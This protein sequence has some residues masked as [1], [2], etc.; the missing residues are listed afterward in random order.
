[1]TYQIGQTVPFDYTRTITG[2]HLSQRVWHAVITPPHKEQATVEMFKARGFH[3]FYP[4]RRVRRFINGKKHTRELP[5][6]TRIV[7][8]RF[9]RVPHWDVM[10]ERGIIVGVFSVFDRP[11]EFPSEIIRRLQGLP[12][13]AEALAEARAQLTEI[14]TGDKVKMVQGTLEGHFVQVEAV[15]PDGRIWWNVVGAE[16]IRGSSARG[17][18]EKANEAS[19]AEIQSLAD[20]IMKGAEQDVA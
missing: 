11:I 18:V 6:I 2:G 3:A 19:E 12:G 17:L 5:E 16:H 1:M 10:K 20:Q 15:D 8:V 7:Y 14:L 13:R 9:D 4:K